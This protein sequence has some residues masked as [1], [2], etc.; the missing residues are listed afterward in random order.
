MKIQLGHWIKKIKINHQILK[1]N[2]IDPLLIY[3]LLHVNLLF[4]LV[5]MSSKIIWQVNGATQIYLSFLFLFHM[6]KNMI[7]TQETSLA[8]CLNGDALIIIP[9]LNFYIF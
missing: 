6:D 8:Q 1:N 9:Y 3:L 2:K 5:R 4:M 7:K